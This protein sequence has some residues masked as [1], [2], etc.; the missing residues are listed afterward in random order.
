MN[1]PLQKFKEKNPHRVIWIDSANRKNGGWLVYRR[2]DGVRDL[3]THYSRWRDAVRALKAAG[4]QQHGSSW[5]LPS[6]TQGTAP[7]RPENWEH[8]A[9]KIEV[10]WPFE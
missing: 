1:S 8:P 3:I 7:I 9:E 2:D 5:S 10:A 4:Y 6:T